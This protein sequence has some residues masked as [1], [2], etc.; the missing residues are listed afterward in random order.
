MSEY[1]NYMHFGD[2]T[3][4]SLQDYGMIC[5]KER[6]DEF[7]FVYK[8]NDSYEEGF[9]TETEI[10]EFMNGKSGYSFTQINEF[11]DTIK[12]DSAEFSNLNILGKVYK[13]SKF[14]GVE[15]I[16]GKA[17]AGLS[18]ESVMQMIETE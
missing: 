11:L 10:N 7:Y 18:L 12:Q 13:L 16:L 2:S 3:K 4:Q 17:V 5:R 9:I 1:I 6:S 8:V 15:T 14:F